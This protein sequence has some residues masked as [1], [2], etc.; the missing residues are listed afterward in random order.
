M[1]FLTSNI[2]RAISCTRHYA[3]EWTPLKLRIWHFTRI[4]RSWAC[5]P[6]SQFLLQLAIHCRYFNVTW[7][8]HSCGHSPPTIDAYCVGDSFLPLQ[9]TLMHNNQPKV[10]VVTE[11]QHGFNFQY[12]CEQSI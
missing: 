9:L 11:V 5:L 3:S 10:L 8:P 6:A 4:L 1:G 12:Y 7:Q 2:I